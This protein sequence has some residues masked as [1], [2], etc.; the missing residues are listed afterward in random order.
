[1]ETFDEADNAITGID[2]TAGLVP[3]NTICPGDLG[4]SYF[5]VLAGVL[6]AVDT[7]EP[8]AEFTTDPIDISSCV[9][10]LI[11]SLDVNSVGDMEGCAD[12][13]DPGFDCVDWIKLEYQI[14]GLGWNEVAG[15]SCPVG[16]TSAPGEMIQ[17]GD[18]VGGPLTITSPCVDFGTLLE[19]IISALATSGTEFWQ[20]DNIQVECSMCLLSVKFDKI[21]GAI[22][23]S[24]LNE[25]HWTT[26]HERGND[27]FQVERSLDGFN[28]VEIAQVDG[29]GNSV[30]PIEYSFVDPTHS[31]DQIV[32]Y[33]LLSSIMV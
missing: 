27:Y 1:M 13:V 6:E 18:V 17:L 4:P 28:Y 3:W 14:D 25:I 7:N 23:T 22:N 16:M 15:S 8:P 30:E 9:L 11:I 5:M 32:Y 29:V 12:C 26:M 33:R 19:L 10:G 31:F 24:G 2:N 20:I 21:Q